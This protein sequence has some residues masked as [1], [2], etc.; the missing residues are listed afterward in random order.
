MEK[1]RAQI[2]RRFFC[3]PSRHYPFPVTL[4]VTLTLTTRNPILVTFE[5][6]RMT[7]IPWKFRPWTSKRWT[8]CGIALISFL[9]GSLVTARLSHINQVRANNNRVF[10]LRVYHAVPGKLPVMESRF[11]DTTSKLLPKSARDWMSA[12]PKSWLFDCLLCNHL[13]W[14]P[15]T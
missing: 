8:A 11:R 4:T 6:N 15:R 5:E 3:R 10:E 2:M 1:R 7:L 9:A 14:N 13:R 12:L